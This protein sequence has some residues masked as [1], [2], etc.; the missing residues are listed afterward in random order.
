MKVFGHN[1]CGRVQVFEVSTFADSTVY[2]RPYDYV[3]G[4]AGTAWA[5]KQRIATRW[6]LYRYN[7]SHVVWG[8]D[9]WV[10]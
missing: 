9:V 1:A 5:G 4:S 3:G 8:G 2:V 10:V 7:V 6:G